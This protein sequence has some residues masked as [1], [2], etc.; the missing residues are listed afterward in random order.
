MV[1]FILKNTKTV[2]Q[3]THSRILELL[4]NIFSA[5]THGIGFG[6]AVAGL[7]LLILKAVA[8]GNPLKII[9]F[10]IYGSCLVLLYL[11]ST[12]YHSLIYTRAHKVFQIF[13]HSSIFL[14]IAGSYTPYSLVAIGGDKGWLIFSIIWLLTLAG[15]L[16]YIFQREPHVLLE[17]SMYIFMGWLILFSGPVLYHRLGTSGFWLLVAGG[18]AYTIG[19]FIFGF[20][21]LPLN[22][23]IWHCFVLAGSI[24][25]FF[26][27]LLYV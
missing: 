20:K 6:L 22:H 15:I 1:G 2:P 14:L 18:V 7:V 25:M 12:L 4:D 11:F 21:K 9:T 26:S 5:V 8:S 24:L 27:V 17:C 10:S 3:A 16:F 19:A 13:D 23:S